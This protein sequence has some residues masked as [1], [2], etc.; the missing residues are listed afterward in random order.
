MNRMRLW[1]AK[2]MSQ[3]AG[4][5]LQICVWTPER[6]VALTREIC[7]RVAEPNARG[8]QLRNALIKQTNRRRT[9]AYEWHGFSAQVEIDYPLVGPWWYMKSIG[10]RIMGPSETH[11]ELTP[12]EA[13]DVKDRLRRACQREVEN[14]LWEHGLQHQVRDNTG[15]VT[16]NFAPSDPSR[17]PNEEAFAE[18]EAAIA[19][20]ITEAAIQSR[21][22]PVNDPSVIEYEGVNGFPS[23][24][25]IAHRRQ[26]ERVQFALIHMNNGGTSPTNIF[27]SLA[28]HL[29]Q[30][31]YPNVDAGKID[32]FDVYP[33]DVYILMP[34]TVELVIMKHVNGVY[35]HP[36]WRSAKEIMTEDWLTIIT[37]TIARSRAV[38]TKAE[39]MA[40]KNLTEERGEQKTKQRDRTRG[41]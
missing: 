31:F 16:G 14:W 22:P 17:P 35:S 9:V 38:R 39:E 13:D 8:Q 37:D 33:P 28:T 24:C 27:E 3:E 21:K 41:R 1:R 25:Q 19:K 18:N 34:F 12:E 11:I 23:F 30:K 15:V 29:R 20:A 5:L 32:W 4:R 7:S 10:G 36:E 40:E 26:S 6:S 2:K